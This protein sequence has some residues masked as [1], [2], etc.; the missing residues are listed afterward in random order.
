MTETEDIK[1]GDIKAVHVEGVDGERGSVDAHAERIAALCAQTAMDLL[2]DCAEFYFL[3]DAVTARVAREPL[4]VDRARALRDEAEL[5]ERAVAQATEPRELLA[6]GDRRLALL[7]SLR[8]LFRLA[9]AVTV[10]EDWQSPMFAGCCPFARSPRDSRIEEH[11]FDY[12]RDR[13]LL[14]LEYEQCFLREFYPPDAVGPARCYLTNSGM[15]AMTT[16]MHYVAHYGR[17]GAPILVGKGSYHENKTLLQGMFG[18]RIVWIDETATEVLSA[19]IRSLRPAAVFLDGIGNSSELPVPDIA[20]L[21]ALNG[22]LGDDA[23]WL[24]LDMTCL[25]LS[26][27]ECA[28]RIGRLR[29]TIVVESLLKFHQYGLD[30]VNAGILVAFDAREELWYLRAH[31]GASIADS[32]VSAIPPPNHRRLSGRLQRIQRTVDSLVEHLDRL[33]EH[34]RSS[35]VGPTRVPRHSSLASMRFRGSIVAL[36]VT[37]EQDNPEGLRRLQGQL[38]DRAVTL[39]CPLVAGTSFGFCISR[40][41]LTAA[42][43]RY[44]KPFLRLSPGTESALATERLKS[45]IASALL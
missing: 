18:E 28:A 11:C 36:A 25:P 35:I 23:P 3:L 33:G 21:L 12:K 31:L 10:A 32:S 29:R 5:L 1:G 19:L 34:P 8:S 37:E 16:A 43:T 40:L 26:I 41:Y 14:G 7:P 42:T 9:G 6:L 27:P 39:N 17:A 38:L 45:V 44:G 4:L 22:A 13:H 20:S 2:D 30:L 15:A 24:V